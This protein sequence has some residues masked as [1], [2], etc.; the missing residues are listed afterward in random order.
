[1]TQI[2]DGIIEL[3]TDA[4]KKLGFTSDKFDGFLWKMGDSIIISIIQSKAIGQG[5]FKELVEK[6]ISLNLT[7]KVPTPLVRMKEIVIKNGYER[8]VVDDELMGEVEV[9]EL[10]P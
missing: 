6:I 4:A 10:K 2:N 5:Y 1:M 8:T 9:W 7:V 3:D